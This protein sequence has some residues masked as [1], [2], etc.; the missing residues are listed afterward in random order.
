MSIH[1]IL[2]QYD[3][4]YQEEFSKYHVRSVEM[5]HWDTN[6]STPIHYHEHRPEP[7]CN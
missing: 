3:G 6:H 2:F 7:K 1:S 4:F 5:V